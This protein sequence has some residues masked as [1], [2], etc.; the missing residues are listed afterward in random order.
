MN[1]F[2]EHVY[3]GDPNTVVVDAA[4]LELGALPAAKELAQ[5]SNLLA[6]TYDAA[7]K[8][9]IQKR[10]VRAIAVKG[11]SAAQRSSLKGEHNVHFSEG[12]GY[13]DAQR[14]LAG[15]QLT[16]TRRHNTRFS[17]AGVELAVKFILAP[18]DLV[19]H[20][21]CARGCQRHRAS[22][23]GSSSLQERHVRRLRSFLR[24]KLG[25]SGG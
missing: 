7:P 16:K 13:R 2:G 25:Q 23:D 3:P 5:V 20:E 18:D 17:K 11:L 9:S 6:E 4:R 12:A 14:L 15:K 1:I 8:N 10:V 24:I 19:G 21:T 22:G